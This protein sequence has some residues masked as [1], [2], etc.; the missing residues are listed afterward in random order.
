MLL[1]I[2]GGDIMIIDSIINILIYIPQAILSKI[3][4]I[5]VSVIPIPVNFTEWLVKMLMYSK[6]LFPMELLLF[7]LNTITELRLLRVQVAGLRFIK[8]QIPG[9]SG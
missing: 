1:Q 7:I 3:P 9:M 2:N 8:S 6:Y 4:A 5:D